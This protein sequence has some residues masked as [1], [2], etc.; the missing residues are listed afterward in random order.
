MQILYSTDG[1]TGALAGAHLLARLGLTEAWRV[2]LLTV[3]DDDPNVVPEQAQAS[4]QAVLSQ[5][6]AQVRGV[7][8]RGHVAEEILRA[9][10]EEPADLAVVGS[11]GL[12]GLRRFFLGSVAERVARHAH[13]SV[14]LAR[15]LVNDLRRV[16]LA[17][18]GSEPASRAEAWMRKLP[19]PEEC[20]LRVVTAMPYLEALAPSRRLA[21]PAEI[22]ALY[23]QER[24]GAQQHLDALVTRL[25]LGG[26]QCAADLLPGDAATSLLQYA[27]EQKA[28]LIAMGAC[29]LTAMQ[30]FLLGSVS[31]KVL[32]H[33]PCSV[34]IAR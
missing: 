32:R 29:G 3:S 15:P 13:C 12:S 5:T 20:E 4:A 18:D 34:L 28:D 25:T 9:L 30:R 17:T 2:I 26:R 24:E 27:E 6:P 8:R 10:E 11:R 22:R 1:S 16:I 19:L 14:L 23:Q 31:E 7:T 33:V 21:W